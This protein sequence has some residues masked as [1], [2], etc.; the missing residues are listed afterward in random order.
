MREM[1]RTNREEK[2]NPNK[3]PIYAEKHRQKKKEDLNVKIKNLGT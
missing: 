1:D 2:E 3:R